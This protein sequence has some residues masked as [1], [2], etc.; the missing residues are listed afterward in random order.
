MLTRLQPDKTTACQRLGGADPN[1]FFP[2]NLEY[3]CPA[4]GTWNIVHTGM[5]I[6]EAQQ[7][8]ACASGCLR[9]VVLT[10]A[11]M[12]EVWRKRFSTI[13]IKEKDILMTDNEHLLINGVT[14]ILERLKKTQGLPPAVLLFTACFHHFIG[15]DLIYVYRQ[16]RQRFPS[17]A[18]AECSMDPIRQTKSLKP[19]E[20]LRKEIVKLWPSVPSQAHTCTFFGSNLPLALSSEV[21][22]LC[23]KAG[24]IFL[25]WIRAESYAAFLETGKAELILWQHPHTLPA[26]RE[27][28]RT[29][30]KRHLYLPQSW[31]YEE[32]EENL[33]ALAEA[34]GTAPLDCPEHQKNAESGWQKAK[35]LLGDA[36]IALDYS[37]TLRPFS[38]ARFLV[39]QGF[40][41]RR[42]YAEAAGDDRENFLW[43]QENAPEIEL[44]STKHPDLRCLPENA[45]E[46]ILALGQKAAYFTQTPYFVNLVD[47]GGLFGFTGSKKL[48][49]LIMEAYQKPKDTK[50]LIRR[51]GWGGPC[52]IGEV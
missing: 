9:G 28:A 13:E 51:K 5:L 44:W 35:S 20:R 11:E 12:G 14:E 34:L 1:Q 3:S 32:I 2:H 43:L 22:L 42:I 49:Q 38:L 29:R 18:F 7:I 31:R 39:E 41:L 40:N 36:P 25:D 27:L 37:F 46:R 52:A 48:S 10:A 17:V 23:Q 6:P 16:L 8:Y 30:C 15:C 19:E 26:C 24:W 50:N 45:P 21:H 33:S 47:G 4:R